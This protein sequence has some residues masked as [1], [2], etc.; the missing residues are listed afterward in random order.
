MPLAK[1]LGPQGRRRL[2]LAALSSGTIWR[3]PDPTRGDGGS[4]RLQ[5]E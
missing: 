2:P 5:S 3:K 1:A 4:P